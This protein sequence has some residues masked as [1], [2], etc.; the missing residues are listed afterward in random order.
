MAPRPPVVSA[1]SDESQDHRSQASGSAFE[2]LDTLLRQR[3][4]CRAFESRAVP[5]QVIATILDAA[6]RTASWCNAQPWLVHVASGTRLERLRE[7]LQAAAS[8]APAPDIAWPGEYRG[9]YQERR[10]ACGWGLY[11]SLGIKRGDRAASQ[12]QAAENFRLFGAPHVAIISSDQALGTYGCI[13]CGAYV[14]NFLL[15]AASLGVA[16]VAQAAVAA[17]PEVLRQQLGIGADRTIVCGIAFGYEDREHPANGFRVN[18]AAISESV[19][20]C[21]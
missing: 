15:A 16:A 19:V 17:C 3:H 18:R 11:E 6:Q 9:V 4:S 2:N 1:M 7:G 14:A 8:Q 5:R 12:A 21:D 13:D 10:R 20:W